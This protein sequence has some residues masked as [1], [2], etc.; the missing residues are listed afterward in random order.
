LGPFEVG[1]QQTIECKNK[2]EKGGKNQIGGGN[3]KREEKRGNGNK[4][5]KKKFSIKRGEGKKRG[6][7]EREDCQVKHI[8]LPVVGNM[9]KGVGAITSPQTGRRG[10]GERN[11]REGHLRRVYRS[12]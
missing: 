10:K 5:G 4:G 8:V 12:Y 7:G 11:R 2:K 6:W 3:L 1:R 9:R